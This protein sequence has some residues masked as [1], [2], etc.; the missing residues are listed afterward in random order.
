MIQQRR[1]K[2]VLRKLVLLTTAWIALS[3]SI[4][5]A[6][7]IA[8]SWQGTI[9][10][11]G[12]SRIVLQ[13]STTDSG[14]LKAFLYFLDRGAMKLPVNAIT[15]K[16]STLSFPVT[17]YSGEYEG[18]MSADGN[19]IVGAW[20]S[21][22]NSILP[23]TLT[24]AI[25]ETAWN[26]PAPK[27]P[28]LPPMAADAHPAFEVATIEPSPPGAESKRFG[29]SGRHFFARNV[30][31]E[32]LLEF[33]YGLQPRQ[34]LNA[35]DWAGKT[36]YNCAGEPDT[37]G[38]PDAAQ[39]R[40]MYQ[41]LLAARFKLS[42]HRD[43]KEFP[44]YALE[45]DKGG[46][47]LTETD[48]DPKDPAHVFLNPAQHGGWTVTFVNTKMAD[49][50]EFLMAQA[51]KDRQVVNHTGLTG[52]FGF[53]LTFTADLFAPDAGEAPDIF[54]AVQKQ[55]GLKL[56]ATKAPIEVIVI[57]RAEPPSQN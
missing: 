50:D 5:R 10:A 25:P 53:A 36:K 4:A 6:Q 19:S 55:L 13:I 47:R 57:D 42:I 40:E 35:P 2:P 9:D 15:F 20:R 17:G 1:P 8:G 26:I 44:V 38:Q 56:E 21:G 31:L 46:P 33:A 22:D 37:A 29:G 27:K 39:L 49:F 12:P 30:T 18:K 16:T 51:I 3:T 48:S 41:K 45:L 24:R 54:H 11:G 23:V 52:T 32:D 28:T 34:L 14:T 7:D 43:Q